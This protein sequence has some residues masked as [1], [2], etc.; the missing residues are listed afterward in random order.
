MSDRK[1]ITEEGFSK[2]VQEICRDSDQVDPA[3][4]VHHYERVVAT[5]KSLAV[6]VN[7]D[8]RMVIP[9]AW[10]HDFV[11][12]S[13]KDPRR[14]QA[15]QISSQAAVQYLKQLGYPEQYLDGISHAIEAHSYSAAIEAKTLEAK[16]V[17]D[18]DRLDALGA[19]GVARCFSQ[20]GTLG[21][22]FYRT[23]DPLCES[24]DPQDS[25]WTVDHFYQKLFKIVETLHTESARK[26]GARRAETMQIYLRELKREIQS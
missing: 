20:G 7:A 3:H 24:R 1:S 17:Q 18:A 22:P 13:K 25:I 4:D 10:F 6:E 26:E 15:S 12:I 5:A 16:V 19:I 8:L 23:E 14:K 9:A 11:V 21:R 2:K